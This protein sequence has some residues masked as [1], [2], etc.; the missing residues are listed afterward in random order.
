MSAALDL[1]LAVDIGTSSVRAMVFD[2]AGNVTARSQVSYPTIR[3]ALYQEEQDPD[4]I[5][6]ETY[7]AMIDC[8]AEPGAAPE[9]VGAISFSSQ[10][11]SIIALDAA[12]RP[13]TR[14]IM[15][16]DGRAEPQ[17]EAMKAAGVQAAALSGHRLPDE[18]DL[19]D[20]QTRLA[21]GDRRQRFSGRRAASFRSRST[22]SRRSSTSG[23]SIT[24]WPRPRGCSTSTDAAGIPRRSTSSTSPRTGCR[25]LSPAPRDSGWRLDRLSPGVGFPTAFRCS[26]AA[27]MGRSPTSAQ[28][29]R[30][31]SRQYRSRHVGRGAL[32][33]HP[34]N[35][36][37]RRQPMVLLPD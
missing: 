34:S 18:L 15:W 30:R 5:R 16:S 35:R 23:P 9:R 36:R 24:R 27:A 31:R 28:A 3:P 19:P 14:N 12:D 2:V 6:G 8:L 13:M 26:S 1:V 10:L 25:R 22:W 7:R 21:Q 29:P 33:C 37:R 32:H 20:R 4:T 17:A 11:Y